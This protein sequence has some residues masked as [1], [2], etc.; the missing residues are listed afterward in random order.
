MVFLALLPFGHAALALDPGRSLSQYVHDRW[1]A[2]KGFVGGAVYAIAQS[3]DG[4]LWIG[5]ERGLVRFDGYHFTL[6]QRPIPESAPIGAVRDLIPDAEGNLWIRLTGSYML[7][8]RNGQFES[9]DTQFELEDIIFTAAVG[10]GS[11]GVLFSGLGERTLRY[12]NGK[13]ET[14]LSAAASPG[15]VISMAQTRDGRIWLGTRDN[16]LFRVTAGHVEKVG[17]QPT[18]AK[19]NALAA[20]SNGGL[21]VGTSHGMRFWDGH[22]LVKLNLP[23]V[24]DQ[25]QILALRRDLDGNIWVGTDRGLIRIAASGAVSLEGLSTKP[26]FEVTAVYEDRDGDLWLGGSRGIERFRNG[27]FATYSTADGLP[28]DSNG[29]VYAD[30]EGRTWFAPLA[31]GLYWMKDGQVHRV[32]LDGLDRDVVYSISG[33]KDSV[34][35]GRQRGGLTQLTV[36]GDTLT[37]RSF[38]QGDGLAQDS[39]Y[40]VHCNRDGTVWAGTV[41]AGISHL[42]GG[43]FTNY[44]E[45]NGL[46]SNTIN[47]IEEAADGTI[48][49]ATP[50]G[51]ASFRQ[52]RWSSLYKRDGLPSKNI[53]TV[54]EDPQHVLWIA[55]QSGLA[56]LADGK[57]HIPAKLPEQLREQIFG[58]ADDT[59]GSL[60]FATS[61]HVLQ[62]NRD[63]LLAGTLEETDAQVYGIDDGLQGVEGVARDR[64]VV[65][66][67]QGRIWVSLDFGLSVADPRVT[68][69]NAIPVAVRMESIS[70]GGNPVDLRH[71]ASLPAGVQNLIFDF[72]GTNLSSP[73]RVHFRYKLEGSDQGWSDIIAARQVVYRNLGPGNYT[74][75]I[76]A[77]NSAG[78]WNGP[79][80]LF[81]FRIQPAFWQT[82]WFRGLM[83]AACALIVL[84]LYRL[85]MYQL[86]EQLNI[87]FQERLAERSR[88]A[89]DLHD[90]LLQGVLSASM[91][92][93]VVEDRL[94]ENSP[95]K[96]PLQR[97]LQLMSKVIEEGRNALR[98]LRGGESDVRSLELA[99]SRMRQ[100]FALDDRI[101]YRVIVDSVA[102]PLRPLIRDEVYRVGREALVNAFVHAKANS[103]EVELDY[104]NRH[105]TVAVRDDGV[106]IDPQVLYAGREGHLGLPGM[107]ERS[108]RIGASLKLRSRVGAGTEVEL[109][110]PGAI[111]YEGEARGPLAVWLP[112]LNRDRFKPSPSDEKK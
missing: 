81:P 4:Y 75:H 68:I 35:V 31:G 71:P 74:F 18:D 49:L 78:L 65:A 62:V 100:E 44:S 34:W 46:P 53:R 59:M 38:A 23:P 109:S 41:S 80:T 40:S 99:F 102:R 30:S 93:D 15:I 9:V 63:R 26:G 27:K 21:W 111:A 11:K 22:E 90:T 47:A 66:D 103:I 13:F 110:V 58:I 60:W 72:A 70:A 52:A 106:G 101:V 37:A 43:K 54:Y 67:P 107:R 48:W 2:D 89:Q 77:S 82:E 19:I 33:G 32:T 112:W 87:R 1:G 97:I 73:D 76:V 86:T 92:L 98:G 3:A 108:E 61:D 8:Y 104:A 24:I 84:G 20:A 96:A 14:V 94:P 105:L 17:G 42:A 28:S 64:T 95:A 10:L 5:T 36:S 79:D 56:Y 83:L 25:L 39:V 85:R 16:G 7:R 57:M 88:I 45:A 50:G 29:P 69:T 91:Q 12:L 6:I 55:T 51:L